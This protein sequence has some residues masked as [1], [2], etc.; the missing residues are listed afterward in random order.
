MYTMLSEPNYR[1][2]NKLIFRSYVLFQLVL[3]YQEWNA[4]LKNKVHQ[5][6]FVA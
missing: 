2:R 6:H 1:K 3:K 5:I 4:P